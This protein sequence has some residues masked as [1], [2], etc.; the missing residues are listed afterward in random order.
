[1]E[2]NSHLKNLRIAKPCQ[3]DWYDMKGTPGVRH[4]ASCKL[5][6]YNLSW[7]TSEEPEELLR[8]AKERVC[9]RFYRRADGTIL[10]RDCPVGLAVSELPWLRHISVLAAAIL[11]AIGLSSASFVRSDAPGPQQLIP[12]VGILQGSH[13]RNLQVT[14]GVVAQPIIGKIGYP[15]AVGTPAGTPKT[16]ESD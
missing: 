1:M 9:V 8:D 12:P 15:P 13:P 16:S 3:A 2:Q 7:M 11:A 5:N 6:V 10:I 14:Q 4:C